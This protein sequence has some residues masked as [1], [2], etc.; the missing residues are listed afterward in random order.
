MA[1]VSEPLNRDGIADD[2]SSRLWSGNGAAAG[3]KQLAVR[4]VLTDARRTGRRAG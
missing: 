3:V 1:L 4:R 2:V